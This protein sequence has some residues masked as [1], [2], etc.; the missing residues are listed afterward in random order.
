[1]PTSTATKI[2]RIIFPCTRPSTFEPTVAPISTPAATGAA[3]NGL[4]Q[5]RAK[6]IPALAAAVTPIMKL[7]VAELT[8]IG[9]RIAKSIAGTLSAPLPIPS[10]PLTIPATYISPRPTPGRA[11]LYATTRPSASS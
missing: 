9:R 11:T 5:P 10:R 2:A 1:M 7:L 3:M 8:L 6:N 4:I